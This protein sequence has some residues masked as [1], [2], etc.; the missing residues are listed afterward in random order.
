MS[1]RFIRLELART[2][3]FPSGSVSRAYLMRLP[4]GDDDL[5][6]RSAFE[7]NPSRASVRRYW[8]TD[9]DQRGSIVEQ[10]ADWTMQF[11]G[12]RRLLK[13]N[14]TPL[15]LGQHVT[16]VEPDGTVLPFQIAS[17]R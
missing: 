17:I 15:R 16:V 5:I 13:M 9:A 10:G 7:Q 2:P 4:V 8:S 14:G 1:W 6:D 12:R 11:D 3:E